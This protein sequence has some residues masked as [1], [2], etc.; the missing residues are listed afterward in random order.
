VVSVTY[1]CGRILGFLDWYISFA[2]SMLVLADKPAAAPQKPVFPELH[3]TPNGCGIN[4]SVLTL[5]GIKV[6]Y[7]LYHKSRVVTPLSS[8][9]F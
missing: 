3:V 9:I 8:W 2:S 5:L 4:N 6:N 7:D 1:P